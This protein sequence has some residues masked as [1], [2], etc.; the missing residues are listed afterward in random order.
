M[1]NGSHD[2]G[3][4]ARGGSPPGPRAS[5]G[6]RRGRRRNR[7]RSRPG[8]AVAAGAAECFC[9]D[10]GA[11]VQVRVPGAVGTQHRL[12]QMRDGLSDWAAGGRRHQSAA[13]ASSFAQPAQSVHPRGPGTERSMLRDRVSAETRAVV[14]VT[15]RDRPARDRSPPGPGR[16]PQDRASPRCVCDRRRYSAHGRRAH[17]RRDRPRLHAGNGSVVDQPPKRRHIRSSCAPVAASA[18]ST[19]RASFLAVATRVSARTLAYDRRPPA[20]AASIAGNARAPARREPFRAPRPAPARF[21]TPASQHTSARPG[22]PIPRTRQSGGCRSAN[23]AF[24]RRP[25]RPAPRFHRPGKAPLR[26]S[27]RSL[28]N[29]TNV[30]YMSQGKDRRNRRKKRARSRAT[31]D[32]T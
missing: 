32:S 31:G 5:C 3:T 17:R 27:L 24:R 26:A 12:F 19:S 20:I 13:R 15:S 8:S 18:I 1:G 28:G 25:A 2:P 10:A 21:A 16:R 29:G 30:Q 7:P 11:I 22:V 6:R 23:D 9:G 4:R 14:A